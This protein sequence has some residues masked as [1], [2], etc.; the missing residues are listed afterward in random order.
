MTGSLPDDARPDLMLPFGAIPDEAGRDVILSG[1]QADAVLAYCRAMGAKFGF[2]GYLR[3]LFGLPVNEALLS[4]YRM[5]QRALRETTP[6]ACAQEIAR[7]ALEVLSRLDGGREEEDRSVLDLFAGVG[8]MAYSYAKAGC[9]VQAVDNDR[10]TVDVAV[11][12]MALAGLA[13]AVEYR[14][15]DGP[16]TLASAVSQDRRFSIVNLDPPWRGSYQYDLN[17]P[18]MLGDLA[19]D[20]GELV[21][22]GLE[23]ARVVVLKLPHN[24]L[25]A[26]IGD[27]AALAGCNVLVQYLYVA[28]FPASFGQAPA[29]F[30]GRSGSGQAGTAGYQERHQ[31]LTLDGRRVT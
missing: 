17:R 15:A 30:F 4:G 8:Q 26:Q 12:N 28:D 10:T 31:R 18:F 20:V 16:A 27:L 24:A 5:T 1:D 9:R 19:V 6:H 25:S 13:G 21:R 23:G 2:P 22:L 11:H 3:Y 29:Y 14:L 7:T